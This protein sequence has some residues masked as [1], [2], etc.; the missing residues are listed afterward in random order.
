M[1]FFGILVEQMHFTQP[2]CSGLFV[3]APRSLEVAMWMQLPQP[4]QNTPCI[5]LPHGKRGF[6]TER[7]TVSQA[8]KTLRTQVTIQPAY[9]PSDPSTVV[10][11]LL[12]RGCRLYWTWQRCSGWESHPSEMPTEPQLTEIIGWL[13]YC[14]H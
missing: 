4:S 2:K 14:P 8:Q 12:P 13:D 9:F 1:V 5:S 3:E 6:P 7:T 11:L 10:V